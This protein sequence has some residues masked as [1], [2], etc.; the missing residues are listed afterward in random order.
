[1]DG[2]GFSIAKEKHSRRHTLAD[3][4]SNQMER[5]K[6]RAKARDRKGFWSFQAPYA[7]IRSQMLLNVKKKASRKDAKLAKG[8][9]SF[10]ETYARIRSLEGRSIVLASAR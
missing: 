10:Q 3:G 4:R 7:R 1:M 8:F 6:R 2:G 9:W 5:K